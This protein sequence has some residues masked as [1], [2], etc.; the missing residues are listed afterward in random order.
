MEGL[1][2]VGSAIRSKHGFWISSDSIKIVS[3]EK[4]ETKCCC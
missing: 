2:G 1:E 4:P 3:L